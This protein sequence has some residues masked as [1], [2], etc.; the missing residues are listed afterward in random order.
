MPY[1]GRSAKASSNYSMFS[2]IQ[3]DQYPESKI[4]EN[5]VTRGRKAALLQSVLSTKGGKEANIRKHKCK[6]CGGRFRRQENLKRHFISVHTEEKPYLCLVC[7]MMF[8]RPDNLGHHM[9]TH[10]QA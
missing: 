8:S 7:D 10:K 9:K 1:N 5:K 6:I 4:I 3:I 2:R